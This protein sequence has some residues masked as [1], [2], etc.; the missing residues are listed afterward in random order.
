MGYMSVPIGWWVLSAI[1]V[2]Y[3]IVLYFIAA[4]EKGGS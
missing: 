3:P 1:T 4:R 2:V